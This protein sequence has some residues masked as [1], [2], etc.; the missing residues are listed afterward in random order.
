[1]GTPSAEG[2]PA[3]YVNAFMLFTSPGSNLRRRH[4][5][6][7]YSWAG[8]AGELKW[9][10]ENLICYD[11]DGR[12]TQSMSNIFKWLKCNEIAEWNLFKT[13]LDQG[14]LLKLGYLRDML[15]EGDSHLLKLHKEFPHV[16]DSGTVEVWRRHRDMSSSSSFPIPSW[17]EEISKV[18]NPPAG[19]GTSKPSF[20]K[21]LMHTV[22]C[23][24]EFNWYVKRV[25]LGPLE[26]GYQFRSW[27]AYH[28]CSKSS[29]SPPLYSLVYLV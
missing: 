2:L 10:R 22:D 21:W 9:P 5:F 23:Q 12:R 4:E 14:K 3:Y 7:S 26:P 17:D 11:G 13:P 24:S 16:F 20:S 18:E 28:G 27:I 6:A 29:S 8:W 25:D 15:R 19:S 1:M